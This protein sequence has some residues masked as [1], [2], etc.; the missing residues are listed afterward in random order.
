MVAK[1]NLDS[2]FNEGG[3]GYPRGQRYRHVCVPN[4]CV[5]VNNRP[6]KNIWNTHNANR[7]GRNVY[8]YKM[9][10]AFMYLKNL[11]G[12]PTHENSY[13]LFKFTNGGNS[14]TFYSI[15]EKC[16]SKQSNFNF[17]QGSNKDGF[18]SFQDTGWPSILKL[19]KDGSKTKI[20]ILIILMRVN[21]LIY[22]IIKTI[23]LVIH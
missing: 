11:D 10:N 19:D 13:N 14:P 18:E 5:E 1:R 21:H 4:E 2:V 6:Y 23:V 17:N 9:G 22:K 15:K 3:T 7:S 16:I 12:M 8:R 20:N